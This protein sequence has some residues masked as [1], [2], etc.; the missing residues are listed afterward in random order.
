[1]LDYHDF[2]RLTVVDDNPTPK[3]GSDRLVSL[4]AG[5]MVD[6]GP[7]EF[8]AI[9]ATAGWPAVGIWFDPATWTDRTAAHVR[10]VLDDT[11][12]IALDIEP[13]ILGPD[14]DIGDRLIDAAIDVG[15]RHVLVASRLDDH[16]LVADRFGALCDRAATAGVSVVLEFLPIFGIRNLGD[17]LGV[18][19]AVA[20]PNAGVLVDTLHLARSG[21]SPDDLARMPRGLLP[22]IQVADAP[23]SLADGSFGGLVDEALHGRLLLGDGGLPLRDVLAAVPDV[24]LSFELR[25]RDLMANYPDPLDRARAVLANWHRFNDQ[26]ND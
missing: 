9:A 25:S 11:G 24:P 8:V 12:T 17:A 5:T 20:R 3:V 23:A 15:A 1:M 16:Q 26:D 10:Q 6:V 21:G 19:Q 18:V 22:Y 14:G 13:V 2:W 7:E 4:A